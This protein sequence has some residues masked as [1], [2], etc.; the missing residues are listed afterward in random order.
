MKTPVKIKIEVSARHCHLSKNDTEKLFGAGYELKK[1]KQLS[2]PA[3]FAAEET[4]DIQAGLKVLKSIR[5][6]GPQREQT[7]IEISKTDAVFLGINPPLRQSGNLKGSLGVTLI[8]PA[9]K[10]ELEEG[11]I[12]AKNHIHCGTD[13]AKELKLKD[14]QTLSVKVLGERP[15]IFEDALVRVKDGYKFSMHLDTDEA[16]AAFINKIGEGEIIK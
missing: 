5:V 8:G 2:Q 1:L 6:V 12:I 10:I 11:L 16:N 9:G 7:Q 4:V 14:G 3:E 13:E 15:V